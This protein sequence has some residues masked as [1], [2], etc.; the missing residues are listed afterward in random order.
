MQYVDYYLSPIGEITLISNGEYLTDL[1]FT[2]QRFYN[3][4]MP[5]IYNNYSVPVL[6]QTKKWLDIYF[7]GKCPN[8]IPNIL[9]QGSAFQLDVWNLLKKIPYGE[10]MTYG[11][12]AKSI[13]KQYGINKMSAQAVGVAVGRNPISIIIPCH[14]VIGKNG[15]LTGYGGGIQRKIE[16]LKLENSYKENFF[17]PKKGNAL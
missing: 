3:E 7:S 14:R 4:T 12:I 8:F 6:I 17:I 10:V 15:N 13:A 9:I 2:G 5:N 1:I 11:D 16:L